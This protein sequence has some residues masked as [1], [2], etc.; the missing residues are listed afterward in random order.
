MMPKDEQKVSDMQVTI[1]LR[2]YFHLKLRLLTF[3][4]YFFDVPQWYINF[5]R[6]IEQNPERYIKT[7]VEPPRR[8]GREGGDPTSPN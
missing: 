6:D 2:F 4:G 3:F 7:T 5:V 1:K 8:N